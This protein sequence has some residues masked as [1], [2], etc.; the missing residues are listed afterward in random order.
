[1]RIRTRQMNGTVAEVEAMPETI[2]REF[3]RKLKDLHQGESETTR[4]LTTVQVVLGLQKLHGDFKTLEEAGIS[5][6]VEVQIV[7]QEVEPVTLADK[8]AYLGSMEELNSVIIPPWHEGMR[9]AAFQACRS[10]IRVEISD[11]V[12]DIGEFAFMNCD[13]LTTVI[14]PSFV[15]RIGKGAFMNCQRLTALTIPESVTQIGCEAFRNCRSLTEVK[16]PSLRVI[17]AFAFTSCV[18]LAHVVISTC[19]ELTIPNGKAVLGAGAFMNCG[20]LE[21]LTIPT[22]VCLAPDA[23]SGCIRLKTP[24]VALEGSDGTS[25]A[26]KRRWQDVE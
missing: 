5:D 2:L 20:S 6:D 26:H 3:K 11:S 9:P 7:F 14:L 22:S 10:L 23:F 4:R 19:G 24:Q 1:M 8:N 12:R 15:L 13:Q 25:R 18:A 16:I 21:S 17:E